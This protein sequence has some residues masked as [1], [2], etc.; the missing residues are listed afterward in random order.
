MTRAWMKKTVM[1]GKVDNYCGCQVCRV[2]LWWSSEGKAEMT[3]AEDSE[4]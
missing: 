4:I 2:C 3:G 1:A